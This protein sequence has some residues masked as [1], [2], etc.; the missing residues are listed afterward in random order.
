MYR[1]DHVKAMN[2]L[3]EMTWAWMRLENTNRK[4]NACCGEKREYTRASPLRNPEGGDLV[5]H[6]MINVN[7]SI[8]KHITQSS[9]IKKLSQEMSRPEE[10]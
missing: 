4:A 5:R 9:G 7:P 6:Y 2:E 8:L 3:S 1:I 10:H